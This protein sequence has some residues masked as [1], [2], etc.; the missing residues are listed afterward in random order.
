MVK[1]NTIHT[2]TTVKAGQRKNV[3]EEKRRERGRGS[4]PS[5]KQG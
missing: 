3:K 2:D 1:T 5:S 4:A